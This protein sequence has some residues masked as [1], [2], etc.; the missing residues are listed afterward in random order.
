VSDKFNVEQS[1]DLIAAAHQSLQPISTDRLGAGPQIVKDAYAVQSAVMH[2]LGPNGGF[3]TGRP[4]P[5]Q[6]S[7]M[8]PILASRIRPSPAHFVQD[9]MRLVGVEIEIAFGIDA[10]LPVIGQSGYDEQ[11]RD[12]I[13]VVPAIEMVDTRFSDHEQATDLTKLADNQFGYGLIVGKPVKDF[14]DLNLTNPAVAFTVDGMQLG[15]TNG[16]IPGPVDAFQV[17]K[18]FLEVVGDHCGGLRPGMYIT[19]GALSGLHWV[20]HGVNVE[21]SIAALGSVAVTIDG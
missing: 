11:L 16:Q 17:L 1:A 14:V 13:S 20:E 21:G 8:A 6:P 4:D 10:E 18:D 2:Q 3:K 9:E 19:T 12:A 7:I 5:N 15:S